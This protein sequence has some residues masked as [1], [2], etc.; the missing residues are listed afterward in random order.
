MHQKNRALVGGA[1]LP[2]S[3]SSVEIGSEMPLEGG[4]A[5]TVRR[6]ACARD[7]WRG[8][9]GS[10]GYLQSCRLVALVQP[11]GT[12]ALDGQGKAD[13]AVPAEAC[14]A[15]KALGLEARSRGQHVLG[16]PCSSRSCPATRQTQPSPPE[17]TFLREKELRPYHFRHCYVL[18]RKDLACAGQVE[19]QW[20]RQGGCDA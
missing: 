18:W 5:Q 16:A 2:L 12:C 15:R 20:L 3:N 4:G 10:G 14:P 13:P 9:T 1:A 7:G 17:L 11:G 6:P 19:G 8:R